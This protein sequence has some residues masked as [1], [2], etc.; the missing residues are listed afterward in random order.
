MFRIFKRLSLSRLSPTAAYPYQADEEEGRRVSALRW[1]GRGICHL[2][3][4][5]ALVLWVSFMGFGGFARES[6]VD[7][8]E[9]LF[10][11]PTIWALPSKVVLVGGI[12]SGAGLL[13][14][15][16]A[17]ALASVRLMPMLVAFV[18]ELR[19]K[20]TAPWKLYVLSTFTAITSWVFGMSKLQ[21]LPRYARV[22]FF[23]GFALSLTTGA[24]VTTSI[25]YSIAGAVP[26]VI[27]GALFLTTPLYFM[28]TLPSAARILSDRLALVFGVLLGPV[29]ALLVPG[30][31]L[32]WTGLVGGLL[33]YGIG[34]WR[35]KA[36]AS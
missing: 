36:V 17:V 26:P 33:A 1:Y 14:L 24:M 23:A 3:S 30:T 6:G 28:L 34:Y 13:A 35:R 15:A 31:D 25:G 10:M 22:P 7:L 8:I 9:V 12:V 29:F 27:A 21:A 4:T 19:D 11:V 16:T 32:V 2:A 20:D 5:P 18:P